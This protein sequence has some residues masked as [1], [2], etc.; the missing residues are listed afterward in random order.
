MMKNLLCDEKYIVQKIEDNYYKK[1]GLS[2]II[3]NLKTQRFHDSSSSAEA[4]DK[5]GK[6]KFSQWG[7]SGPKFDLMVLVPIGWWEL[8]PSHAAAYWSLW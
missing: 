8:S 6:V 2:S 4:F 3:E 7:P 5:Y 1:K